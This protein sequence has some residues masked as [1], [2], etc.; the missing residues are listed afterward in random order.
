M[1]SILLAL[2]LEFM[3]VHMITGSRIIA[4]ISGGR[5]QRFSIAVGYGLFLPT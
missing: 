4:K 5:S 2:I 3:N 1:D